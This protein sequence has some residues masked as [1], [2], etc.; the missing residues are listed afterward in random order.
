MC[1]SD[2]SNYE[3]VALSSSLAVTF[4]K[5]FSKDELIILAAFFTALGDN[6]AILSL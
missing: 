4:S 5:E 2:F 1:I 6:L 3:L